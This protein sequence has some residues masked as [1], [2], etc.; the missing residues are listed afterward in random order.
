MIFSLLKRKTA[1]VGPFKVWGGVHGGGTVKKKCLARPSKKICP[2]C[3]LLVTSGVIWGRFGASDFRMQNY[4]VLKKFCQIRKRLNASVV[5]NRF[6]FCTSL[7]QT[8]LD[9]FRQKTDL[10]LRHFWAI[11]GHEQRTLKKKKGSSP[12]LLCVTCL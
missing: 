1:T 11:P 7:I 4:S 9:H 3:M 12:G 8:L 10:L 2:K 6:A 5:S